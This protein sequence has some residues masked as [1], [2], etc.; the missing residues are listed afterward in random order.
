MAREIKVA[1]LGDASDL[2][3]ATASASSDLDRFAKHA[4]VVGGLVSAG[5][6]AG[7]TALAGLARSSVGFLTDSIKQAEQSAS[8]GKITAQ[9]IETTGAA[10]FTSAKQV[11]AYATQLSNL[12]GIDDELIQQGEN[13]LLT[14]RNVRNETGKGNDIFNRATKVA[15]DM[16]K[17]LGQD[18]T[19]SNIQLGK[20]LADPVKGVT[21][22]RR[23]GVIFTA[24]QQKQIKVLVESGKALEAQK[25]ILAEVEHE[26]GG[27]AEAG[28]TSSEKLAVAFNNLKEGI[29]TLLLPAFAAITD[30]LI[31]NVFPALQTFAQNVGSF[32]SGVVERAKTFGINFLAA[33]K[34]GFAGKI[35]LDTSSLEGIVTSVGEILGRLGKAFSDATV[36]IKAFATDAQPVLDTLAAWADQHSAGVQV[37]ADA[38]AAFAASFLLIVGAAQALAS[39]GSILGFLGK[40]IGLL[41]AALGGTTVIVIGL[42]VAA[43]I[44]LGVG[45]YLAYQ[46]FKGFHD[47][48]DTVWQDIQTGAEATAGFFVRVWEAVGPALEAA[49]S[50]VRDVIGTVID[51]VRTVVEAVPGIFAGIT[52]AISTAFDAVSSAVGVAMD[53]VAT[54]A[55]PVID[56]LRGL[57]SQYGDEVTGILIDLRDTFVAIFD[58]LRD[59]A[60]RAVNALIAVFNFLAPILEPI[61]AGFIRFVQILGREAIPVLEF[62]G[63]AF[64]LAFGLIATAVKAFVQFITPIWTATWHLVL[65]VVKAVIGPLRAILEGVLRVIQGVFDIIAGLFTGDWSRMWDGVKN[66]VS[67]AWEAIA[68]IFLGA[69]GI[70]GAVLGN[71]VDII[72]APFRGAFDA[73]QTDLAGFVD[74][75]SG[76]FSAVVDFFTGSWANLVDFITNPFTVAFDILKVL[77]SD[78]AGFFAGLFQGALDWITATW[79]TITGLLTGP[80]TSAWDT[81]TSTFSTVLSTVTGWF[82]PVI[83]WFTNTW[84]TLE[85]LVKA[86]FDHAWSWI[87]DTFGGI[88]K[89]FDDNVIGPIKKVWNAV[90][91]FWNDHNSITL[92]AIDIPFDGTIG[93]NTISLPS[94]PLFPM[95]TGGIVTNPMLALLG[96]HSKAEV[97]L[98]LD[99]LRDFFPAGPTG[100]TTVVNHRQT[101]NAGFGTD[102]FALQKAVRKGNHQLNRLAGVRS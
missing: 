6:T 56:F 46:R 23:V 33:L 3:R 38:L 97:V 78:V 12:T 93:G 79:S 75:I 74:F 52:G 92:P 81:I 94:L 45:V 99:R 47:F 69:I 25:L 2:N 96:E 100:P 62:L 18:L 102:R 87:K 57:W 59:A 8:I 40:G 65:D 26:F 70:I 20:A 88:A 83:D 16:S 27:A 61:I 82:Q 29:G 7:I 63:R 77:L 13:V 48:I 54:V 39:L 19:K 1:F 50:T 68:N 67:G 73:V 36:A 11:N 53:A 89:W 10:S 42:V 17:V 32:F 30:A 15:L 41:V 49:F 84:S 101:I 37:A 90:A 43:I 24:D 98:P 72:T 58:I 28:A 21:A 34:A 66:I 71:L 60:E 14:F 22:L 76:A 64:T 55:A 51:V 85:N 91:G 5:V 80:L 95:A 9:L 44:A 4:G 86:P 35:T 31:N